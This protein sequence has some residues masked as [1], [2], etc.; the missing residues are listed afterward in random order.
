MHPAVPGSC[1]AAEGRV[2]VAADEDR[3]GLAR[4]G[5]DLDGREVEDLTVVLEV[6][7]GGKAADDGELF[8]HATPSAIPGHAED[9]VVFPP[10]AGPDAKDEPVPGEDGGRCRLLGHENGVAH[11]ELEYIR[12]ELQACGDGAEGGDEREGLEEGLV[13]EELSG[14]VGVERVPA[15]GA[16]RVADAVGEHHRVVP[17]FLGGAS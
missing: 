1:G 15:L 5:G 10:R 8:V 16:F 2:A 4:H 7:A 6:A 14:A 13:L 9:L 17:G 3:D 12:D 11:G